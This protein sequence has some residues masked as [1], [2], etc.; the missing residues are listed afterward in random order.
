[1]NL[2]GP[3]SYSG[4]WSI[5]IVDPE[6]TSSCVLAA[7]NEPLNALYVSVETLDYVSNTGQTWITRTFTFQG[8]YSRVV[9]Y[10][11]AVPVSSAVSINIDDI[12]IIPL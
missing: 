11:D 7:D 9:I 4:T 1:M 8:G 6:F 10:C 12:S 3:G 2:P 5:K